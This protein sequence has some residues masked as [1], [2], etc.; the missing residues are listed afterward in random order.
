MK[1]VSGTGLPLTKGGPKTY[2]S[3]GSGTLCKS[4]LDPD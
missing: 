1:E 4:F 3:Y 2:G